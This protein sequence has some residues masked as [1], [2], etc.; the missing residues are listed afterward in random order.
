MTLRLDDKYRKEEGT[1][2]LT[3]MEAILR[4]VLEKQ[5][6]DAAEGAIN[7]TYI[8]GY[9]GSPLGGL[10]LKLLE[11]IDLLNERGRTLHQ[12]GINACFARVGEFAHLRIELAQFWAYSIQQ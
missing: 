9:E 4:L 5:R 10:D 11:Q 1:V 7:Q 2:F 6:A 3:G 12:F 8:S